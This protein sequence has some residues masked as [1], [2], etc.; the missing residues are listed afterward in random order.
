MLDARGIVQAGIDA[1]AHGADHRGGGKLD[2][3]ARG[4]RAATAACIRLAKLHNVAGQHGAVKCLGGQQ[5]A[6]LNTVGKSKIKLFLVSGHLLLGAAIHQ[7]HVLHASQTLGHASRVH[8]GVAGAN[9]HDVLAQLELL[10]LLGGLEELQHIELGTLAQARR[11]GHP[12]TGG[13]DHVGKALVLELVNG[14]NASVELHLGAKGQAELGIVGDIVARDAELGNHVTDHATERIAGLE[15]GDGHAG[16][17][18]EERGRQAGRAAA[19]NGNGAVAVVCDGLGAQLGQHGGHGLTGGLELAG[20]NLG[21]LGL[22]KCTFAGTAAGMRADGAGNER[23]GVA[24]DD[25]VECVLVA[26]LVNSRQIGGNILLDGAA[27]AARRGK[28]VGK[29]ALAGDLAVG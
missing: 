26:A 24:L 21:A 9:D 10:A 7:A 13:H 18:Q 20:A 28:A 3:L 22:V 27:R 23:Q 2:G 1:L 19:D 14:I 8:G 16:T 11:A 29:R 15:D 12:G 4:D 17:R 5:L 6:E 25:D